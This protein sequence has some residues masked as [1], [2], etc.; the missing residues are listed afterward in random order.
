MGFA[1]SVNIL[2]AFVMTILYRCFLGVRYVILV[3]G[4]LYIILR[5]L[6]LLENVIIMNMWSDYGD[7]L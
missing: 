2:I 3:G 7:R 1:I 5:Y 6:A 4:R